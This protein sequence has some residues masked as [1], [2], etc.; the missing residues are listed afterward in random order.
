[1][2]DACAP[3][4]APKMLGHILKRYL[5]KNLMRE[6]LITRGDPASGSV[7]LTFDDG[8]HPEYSCRILDALRSTGARATFFL[9]GTELEKYPEYGLWYVREGHAVGNHGYYH[10]RNR[11]TDRK[12]V[13]REYRDTQAEIEKACGVSSVYFR[14]PYGILNPAIAR[15]SRGN[16]VPVVLWSIDSHDDR[17][18]NTANI[19]SALKAVGPGDIVLFHEDCAQTAEI[20]E[21]WTARGVESG[22]RFAS[23]GEWK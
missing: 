4:S 22:M 3:Y 2:D 10:K 11:Y 16:R 8:P 14:P 13:D 7:Y 21:E 5:Y 6:L 19:L 15:F 17:S 9:S 12:S 18:K 1:M 23:L 20:L